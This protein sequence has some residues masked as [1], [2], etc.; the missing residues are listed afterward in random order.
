MFISGDANTEN[1]FYCLI[2]T[3]LKLTLDHD[4][5][6]NE[7]IREY[8]TFNKYKYTESVLLAGTLNTYVLFFASSFFSPSD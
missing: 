3:G 7:L 1:V 6:I 5:F 8:L 2:H 4:I